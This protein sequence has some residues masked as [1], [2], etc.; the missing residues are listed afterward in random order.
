VREV[1]RR[2]PRLAE[3]EPRRVPWD[4]RLAHPTARSFSR[5][6]SGQPD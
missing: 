3:T 5:T 1:A 6:R 2:Y 4:V